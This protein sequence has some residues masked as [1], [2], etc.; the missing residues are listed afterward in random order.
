MGVD[1][2]VVA[3]RLHRLGAQ[4]LARE[5]AQLA[6][7]LALGEA[8]ER[9]GGDVAHEHAVGRLDDL[10]QAEDEVAR[11]K[12]STAMPWAPRRLRELDDVDVHAAGVARPGL[13]Q[14]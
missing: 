3:E 11:V 5:G 6:G 4:H 12:T 13:V 8:L 1:G 7:Q 9:A 2:V 14:G 10:R